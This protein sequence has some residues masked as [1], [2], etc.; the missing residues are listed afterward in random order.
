M[1]VLSAGKPYVIHLVPW[2][3]WLP[4]M[5][6]KCTQILIIT[7][8]TVAIKNTNICKTLFWVLHI[9]LEIHSSKMNATSMEIL[10]NPLGNNDKISPITNTSLF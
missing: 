5:S 8:I 2:L 1:R 9:G 4:Q 10:V 6:S 7:S 3:P